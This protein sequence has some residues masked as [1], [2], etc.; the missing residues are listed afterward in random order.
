MKACKPRQ[1][2]QGVMATDIGFE[3]FNPNPRCKIITTVKL[4]LVINH[5]V[6]D[7]RL[8]FRYAMLDLRNHGSGNLLFIKKHH[9]L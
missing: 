9:F 7:N 3:H 4:A 6:G 5:K 2:T 8:M 1:I